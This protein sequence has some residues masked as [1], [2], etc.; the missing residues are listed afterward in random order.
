M[1]FKEKILY[2]VLV[3]WFAI[4]QTSCASTGVKTPVER[5]GQLSVKGMHLVD[6]KGKTVQLKGISSHG[7]QWYGKY[8]NKDVLQWLRDDWHIDVWRAAL[9]LTEGGYIDNPALKQ[10]VIDSIEACKDLG[11]YVIVDWHVLRDKDPRAYKEKAKVFF[12]EIASTYGSYPNVLYEICNEPNGENV[13]WNEAIKPYAEEIIPV[14]RKYDPDNIIIV[15][16]PNWS[17]D[18]DVAAENPIQGNNIMYTLHFYAGTHG[19]ELRDKVK[20]AIDKELPIFVTEWGTTK[21]S[22][23]GGV[24]IKESKEWIAFLNKYSI[25]WVNWSLNNK[26]EDSGILRYN[27]DRE[28]K[29]GWTNDD[30]SPSGKFVKSLF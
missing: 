25:S 24:F 29:G 18:V 19:Q 11:L 3:L 9:Y 17:Q 8:A 26:G 16:T 23:G 10:K 1:I 7:L 6:Q 15:G 20:K 2:F 13:T 12:E 4:W 27:A 28:A 30:L 14:I 22:G 5:Y 21:N